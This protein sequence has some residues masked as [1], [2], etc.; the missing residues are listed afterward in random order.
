MND[1]FYQMRILALEQIDLINK[2]SKKNVIER[3]KRIAEKD[4]KTLVRASAI[5]TLGK[6]TDPELKPIFDKALQ[7]E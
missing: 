1:N 4:P 5:E 6:L 7:S 3:I 2:W